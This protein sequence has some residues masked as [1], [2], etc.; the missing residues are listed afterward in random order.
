M[1]VVVAVS[2][3]EDKRRLPSGSSLGLDL[4]ILSGNSLRLDLGLDLN[5]HICHLLLLRGWHM[6]TTG[7]T[8]K[9][10]AWKAGTQRRGRDNIEGAGSRYRDRN[11]PGNRSG[12]RGCRWNHKCW[13]W[14]YN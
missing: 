12:D 3:S 1:V 5:K 13:N 14:Q 4:K 6:S 10:E 11:H 7:D 8:W 9:K 2:V